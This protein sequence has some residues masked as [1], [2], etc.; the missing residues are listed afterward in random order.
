MAMVISLFV[1]ACLLSCKC[2]RQLGD[3]VDFSGLMQLPIATGNPDR[4][5]DSKRHVTVFGIQ[6]FPRHCFISWEVYA[7]IVVDMASALHINKHDIVAVHDI[8]AA[9]HGVNTDDNAVILQSRG[10]ML[11]TDSRALVLWELHQHHAAEQFVGPD[12][13]QEVLLTERRLQ[14]ESI[15]R[16]ARVPQCEKIQSPRCIVLK[17]GVLTNV[18]AGKVVHVDHGDVVVIH[19]PPEAA[20]YLEGSETEAFADA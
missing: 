6:R 7:R 10:D 15:W 11:L 3:A 5:V 18:D 2:E 1:L 19:V 17:N 16:K 13:K 4:D 12:I 9:V 20:C 8:K 14:R